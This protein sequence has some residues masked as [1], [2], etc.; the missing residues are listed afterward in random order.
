M[1]SKSDKNKNGIDTRLISFILIFITQS[2]Y[3]QMA[4]SVTN[5]KQTP[6]QQGIQGYGKV[7][8]YPE[9]A[10][11]PSPKRDYKVLF[12]ITKA[13]DAARTTFCSPSITINNR[14]TAS[15]IVSGVRIFC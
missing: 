5:A 4:L 11:Q 3:P 9:A 14:F 13:A 12:D 1:K 8:P 15:A 7:H 2:G 10:I 6:T